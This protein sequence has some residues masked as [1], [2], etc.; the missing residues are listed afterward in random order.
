MWTNENHA[1]YDR[2][3]L[4]YPRDLSDKEWAEISPLM[5]SVKSGGNKWTVNVCKVVNGVMWDKI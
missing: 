5:P 1:R 4:P 2:R 3:G